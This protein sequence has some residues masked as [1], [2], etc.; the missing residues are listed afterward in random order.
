MDL[1]LCL[2]V[3]NEAHRL[4]GLL[5][6]LP[7]GDLEVIV[8]DTGSNDE[9]IALLQAA[10]IEPMRIPWNDDFAAA[11]NVTVAKAT[12]R[13][14]LWLDADDRV[15]PS[16]FADISPLLKGPE[17][18]Y[19]CVVRSPREDGMSEAF[20]QIRIF[21]NLRGMAFEGRIHEQLGG[22]AMRAGVPIRDSEL[23]IEHLGYASR[24]E[25]HRKVERNLRML[26]MEKSE[27]PQ[28]S[29]VVLQYGNALVQSGRFADA[30]SAYLSLLPFRQPEQAGM[31]PNDERLRLFPALVAE[32][33]EKE[34]KTDLAL[35]WHRLAW[36]WS[37][38]YLRSGYVLAKDAL[39]TGRQDEA[40]VLLDQIL[41]QPVR[42]GL[43]ACDNAGVRRNA[44]ALAILVADASPPSDR[45]GGAGQP[46]V[47]GLT[48]LRTSAYLQELIQG[49]RVPLEPSLVLSR[50]GRESQW[51]AMARYLKSLR[52]DVPEECSAL[53]DGVEMLLLQAPPE[54]RVGLLAVFAALGERVNLSPVLMA[55]AAMFAEEKMPENAWKL[56]QDAAL[57]YPQDAT[58]VGQFCAFV[59]KRHLRSE[60]ES[61]LRR[62]PQRGPHFEDVLMQ[63]QRLNSVTTSASG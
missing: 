58:V 31:A 50:L 62:H 57:A 42:V 8:A 33:H 17:Q 46:A 59:E 2:I 36:H 30:C 60:A 25:R 19:R 20:R 45:L 43:V 28:D 26:E 54:S 52:V 3:K 10:G 21:P 13:F 22:S 16:F 15:S 44:L 5:A 7:L 61:F 27:H 47:N 56:F 1:S 40:K 55:F 14:V 51:E 29:A 63:L 41:H 37:P 35:R 24:E 9:T 48:R 32:T 11:R 4:P 49:G 6:S 34:G 12:R 38:D 39:T 23:E 53:E 18:A